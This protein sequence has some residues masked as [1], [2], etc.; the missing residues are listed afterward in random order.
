MPG[1]ALDTGAPTVSPVD[2]VPA[3]Q[4]MTLPWGKRMS[5]TDESF[6]QNRKQIK[7]NPNAHQQVMDKQITVYPYN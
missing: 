7:Y 5:G 1:P 6:E 2:K 4:G 3:L